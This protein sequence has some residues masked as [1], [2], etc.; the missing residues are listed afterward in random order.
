M[1]ATNNRNLG[2]EGDGIWSSGALLLNRSPKYP[3]P[4]VVPHDVACRAV[5]SAP[6]WV[7]FRPRPIL[8]SRR[9][10]ECNPEL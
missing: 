7:A 6:Y 5:K 9:S 10:S 8:I 1:K 4:M 3:A 2:D